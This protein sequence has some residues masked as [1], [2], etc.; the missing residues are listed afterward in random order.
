MWNIAKDIRSPLYNTIALIILM[1]PSASWYYRLHT[2]SKNNILMP[3]T[4]NHSYVKFE[5]LYSI[6][7]IAKLHKKVAYSLYL[8]AGM[9]LLSLYFACKHKIFSI[10]LAD[11]IIFAVSYT[12][13]AVIHLPALLLPQL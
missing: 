12:I 8:I 6:I 11:T 2:W 7:K 9:Q 5:M 4:T 3:S 10:L 1:Y 13:Q